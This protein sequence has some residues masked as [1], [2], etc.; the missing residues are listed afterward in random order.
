MSN[1]LPAMLF[2]DMDGVLARYDRWA[3]AKRPGQKAVYETE[4]EHYFRHCVPDRHALAILK[5]ALDLGV[6]ARVLT[7]I[8]SDLPWVRFD[9]V[10]WLA[11]HAPWLDPARLVIASGDKAQA[12]IAMQ[13]AAGLHPGIVLL[14]D[15]N[16]NLEDWARAGGTAVKYLNGVNSPGS[17]PGRK[18]DA[19]VY[20]G[21][22]A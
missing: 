21:R 6:D 13:L 5:T 7:A 17:W 22:Y 10:Q 2:M 16:R 15:F 12:V 18:Y 9:K 4:H 8:R 1:G 14:D 19:R 11:E 3:Y 20:A